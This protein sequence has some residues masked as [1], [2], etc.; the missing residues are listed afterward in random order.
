MSRP[1]RKR[2]RRKR[3]RRTLFSRSRRNGNEGGCSRAQTTVDFGI[4]AGVFLI[5]VA[6]AVAFVPSMLQPFDRG[7]QEETVTADR[8]AD[9]LTGGILGSPSDQG[10]LDV[11]CTAAFFNS[12]R[13]DTGCHFDNARPLRDRVGVGDRIQLHVAVITDAN[14]DGTTETVCLADDGNS[15]TVGRVG[16]RTSG[17]VIAANGDNLGPCSTSFELGETPP[18]E[19]G[20]VV[21]ARRFVSVG[22]LDAALFVRAW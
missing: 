9:Q 7:L 21:S 5:V 8:V 3:G 13:E 18:S 14:D 10:A 4:G 11:A 15:N 19:T 20:S 12:S 1:N 6:F 16:E 2:G 17:G 22:T